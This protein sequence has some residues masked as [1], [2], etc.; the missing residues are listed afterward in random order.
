MLESQSKSEHRDCHY[1]FH[2]RSVTCLSWSQNPV[3]QWDCHDR[4]WGLS[5]PTWSQSNFCAAQI[6]KVV[7]SGSFSNPNYFQQEQDKIQKVLDVSFIFISKKT[8]CIIYINLYIN[9]LIIKI[10]ILSNVISYHFSFQ[11]HFWT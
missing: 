8:D 2:P 6:V 1:C 7:S 3:V 10:F 5:H 11:N 4:S 9:V